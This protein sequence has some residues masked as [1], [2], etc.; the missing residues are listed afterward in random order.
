M[1]KA[2]QPEST[3]K[4]KKRVFSG[5]QPSGGL[6]LGNYLG[7]IKRFVEMQ[8]DSYETIY[9]VVDMHATM[10][11]SVSIPMRAYNAYVH[12][13]IRARMLACTPVRTCARRVG[14][15]VHALSA[16]RAHI[17]IAS[18]AYIRFIMNSWT[19]VY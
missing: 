8:N 15:S 3:G 19:N 14:T 18:C 7:A 11:S 2:V 17:R 9:C 4:F 10:L 5:V 16:M 13:C 1:N 12:T 6:T